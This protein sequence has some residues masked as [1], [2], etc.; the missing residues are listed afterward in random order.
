VATLKY[1]LYALP[2]PLLHCIHHLLWRRCLFIAYPLAIIF[3]NLRVPLLKHIFSLGTG[4]FMAQ[5]VFGSGWVHAAF[6]AGVAYLIMVS[7]EA[8]CVLMVLKTW[9]SVWRAE[10]GQSCRL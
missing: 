3:A 10:C 8:W 1:L 9:R 2:R 6:S 7:G 4:L 5:F